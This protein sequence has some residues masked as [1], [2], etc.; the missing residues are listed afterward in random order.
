M[1]GGVS[2]LPPPRSWPRSAWL[3]MAANAVPLWGVFALDWD[4]GAL[5]WL[6]WLENLVIGACAAVRIATAG[7]APLPGIARV[8]LVPFFLVHFGLF[9]MGHAL[10]LTFLTNPGAGDPFGSAATLTAVRS[11]PGVGWALLAL[12]LSHGYSVIAHFLFGGERRTA[13]PQLEMLKPYGR[14]LVMHL[15]VLAGGALM[16]AFEAP[17]AALVVLTL[18]KT[19]LDL[20]AHLRER[21]RSV[22]AAPTSAPAPD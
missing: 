1:A 3:L 11:I 14:I 16:L 20:A 19:A 22:A 12:V 6:Y 10:V 2:I 15:T 21:A 9:C 7:A 18:M 5:L 13:S 4:A 8:F 17:A